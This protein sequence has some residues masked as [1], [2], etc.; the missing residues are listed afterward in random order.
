MT[1]SRSASASDARVDER[2]R[3]RIGDLP[4]L[5]GVGQ[6]EVAEQDHR[7]AVAHGDAHRFEHRVEALAGE[8]ESL[9]L[10]FE[11]FKKQFE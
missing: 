8:V 11:Q 1:S 7:R 3:I 4:R 5:G 6:E 2:Q 9:R 10:Q